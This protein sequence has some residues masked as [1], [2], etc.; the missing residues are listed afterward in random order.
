MLCV[1]SVA[2][3]EKAGMSPKSIA[4]AFFIFIFMNL[5]KYKHRYS[6]HTLTS[7]EHLRKT[8]PTHLEIDEITTNGSLSTGTSSTTENTTLLNP[9]INP[10]KYE[11]L[12]QVDDLNPGTQVLARE[13]N[14]ARP[15]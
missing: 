8:I 5:N 14:R 10:K 4:G 6:T 1:F 7:Y 11:H 2:I 12:C 9:R 15:I 3:E 13:P